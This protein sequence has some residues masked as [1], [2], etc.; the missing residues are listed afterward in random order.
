LS[1]LDRETV[2]RVAQHARLSLT[3]EELDRFAGQ[4]EVVLGAFADL[5]AVDTEGVEPSYHPIPLEDAT[6]GDEPA[7]W[8][9]DPFANSRHVEGRHFRGPRIT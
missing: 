1:S 8:N 6:R 5:D 4:L 3:A 2:R 9:W 7:A